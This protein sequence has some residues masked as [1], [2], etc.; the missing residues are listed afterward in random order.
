V[1]LL[2]LQLLS[3]ALA[4][5]LLPLLRQFVQCGTHTQTRLQQAAWKTPAQQQQQQ[6]QQAALVHGK[7]FLAAAAAAAQPTALLLLLLQ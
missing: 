6:Q 3:L 1:L 2:L 5:P 7:N 4:V